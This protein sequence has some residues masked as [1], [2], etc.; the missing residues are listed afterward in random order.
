MNLGLRFVFVLIGTV[1]G[2]HVQIFMRRGKARGNWRD[3]TI[4]KV[5][6]DYLS[7]VN[8]YNVR[9]GKSQRL[10]CNVPEISLR[11]R[12]R[13][14][15]PPQSPL[16]VDQPSTV[17]C[18]NESGAHKGGEGSADIIPDES[19]KASLL[20]KLPVNSRGTTPTLGGLAASFGRFNE[21]KSPLAA[22][23][24]KL[25]Q[26]EVMHVANV[27]ALFD[28]CD[29]QRRVKGDK[30]LPEDIEQSA[31]VL[32]GAMDT[33]SNCTV[34][35]SLSDFGTLFL[36]R[37]SCAAFLFFDCSN[38]PIF[39]CCSVLAFSLLYPWQHAADYADQRRLP[40]HRVRCAQN[41]GIILSLT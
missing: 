36:S 3:G 15:T 17:A 7:A 14:P 24:L 20:G 21:Y 18:S 25:V 23:L 41:H 40:L 30:K 16:A 11:P 12:P 2:D 32:L 4:Y 35:D 37:F 33:V 28:E 10:Q 22:G 8:M 34:F 19:H 38:M 27:R 13:A 26:D 1:V 29:T 5:K 39:A 9:I 6:Q 31:K